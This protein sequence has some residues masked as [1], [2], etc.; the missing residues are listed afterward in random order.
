LCAQN[1][2]TY[3]PMLVP[4]V[5]ANF[6]LLAHLRQFCNG[7]VN[8][9]KTQ[10]DTQEISS[11]I[12]NMTAHYGAVDVGIARTDEEFYYSHRGRHTQNY[13]D[14]VDTSSKYAIVFAVEMSVDA[15][16]TA[17][18]MSACL[19]TSKAYVDAAVIGLQ[20]AQFIRGLGY[21]ARCHM[22]GNYLMPA[23]PIAVEAGLGERGRN[24][25]L[26]SRANGCFVRLGI[27]TTELALQT[28]AKANLNIE[29]FCRLCALCVK[30]CP[31][32]TISESGDSATWR[33]EQ[34]KCYKTW[35]SLGTDCGICISACPIGQEIDAENI[36]DMTE[37]QIIAFVDG[38]KAKFGSR[39]RN[40]N[41]GFV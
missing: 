29:R 39:K 27:V 5:E 31:A 34:E 14:A 12:K 2:P 20:I 1:T 15:V 3:D 36:K 19:E 35:R 18:A 23:I 22:D 33:I 37:E 7:E 25:L 32:R 26:I 9:I 40:R 16:N 41:K 28:D 24:S 6:E 10:V 13:G 21:D 30:T 8:A 4:A 11:L 17:P 38:Y